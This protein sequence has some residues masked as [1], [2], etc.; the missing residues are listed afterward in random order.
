MWLGTMLRSKNI[1]TQT[2]YYLFRTVIL[3]KVRMQVKKDIDK[4]GSGS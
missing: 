3:L 2:N 1:Q 4:S